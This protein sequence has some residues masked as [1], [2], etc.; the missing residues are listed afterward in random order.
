MV[1]EVMMEEELVNREGSLSKAE[2][3]CSSGRL[4]DYVMVA[5]GAEALVQEVSLAPGP[6][7]S[8]LGL[9]ITMAWRRP[10]LGRWRLV[11]QSPFPEKTR[12]KGG[13]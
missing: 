7:K 12:W 5:R 3:T 6:W 10:T 2:A 9:S 4:L 8:H 13:T 1:P 11:T